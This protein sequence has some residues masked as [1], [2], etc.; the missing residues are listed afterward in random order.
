MGK[1]KDWALEKTY[2]LM[3]RD[4]HELDDREVFDIYW[5]HVCQHENNPDAVPVNLDALK[6]VE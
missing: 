6:N 5:D 2:E 3:Q 4:G 1:L